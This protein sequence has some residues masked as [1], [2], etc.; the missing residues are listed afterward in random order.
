MAI[1]YK[2][3]KDDVVI[4]IA[5]IF[6]G[7]KSLITDLNNEVTKS[8]PCPFAL[9]KHTVAEISARVHKDKARFIYFHNG[10]NVVDDFKVGG[11]FAYWIAKLQPVYY[12]NGDIELIGVEPWLN[13][14]LAIYVGLTRAN[15]KG[16]ILKLDKAFLKE[17]AYTL[18]YRVNSGDDLSLFFR[19]IA[20]KGTGARKALPIKKTQPS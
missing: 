10:I 12:T 2:E 11:Y 3:S 8:L 18:K 15:Q 19:L 7:Y 5:A 14:F 13:Q 20:T 4:G 9:C 16:L 1:K 17:M 6:D